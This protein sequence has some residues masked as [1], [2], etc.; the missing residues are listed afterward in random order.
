MVGHLEENISPFEN[1]T[2]HTK[3]ILLQLFSKCSKYY[4]TYPSFTATHIT[5][6]VSLISHARVL[7]TDHIKYCLASPNLQIY[8]TTELYDVEIQIYY[9]K[10]K[11]K[12]F[13]RKQ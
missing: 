5:D 12:V 10:D 4:Q 11:N 13:I 1:I 9:S 6:K 2:R 8:P 3:N 7:Q